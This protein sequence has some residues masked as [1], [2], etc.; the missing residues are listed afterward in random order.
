MGLQASKQWVLH[1]FT[2]KRWLCTL[3]G[4]SLHSLHS[5]YSLHWGHWHQSLHVWSTRAQDNH[6]LLTLNPPR[7]LDEKRG[8]L[9]SR[10]SEYLASTHCHEDLL[11][12]GAQAVDYLSTGVEQVLCWLRG[13][14]G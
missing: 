2:S 13:G 9:R 12:L 1:K 7:L 14:G 6:L 8:W 3:L 10:G 11:L 4:H 5:L